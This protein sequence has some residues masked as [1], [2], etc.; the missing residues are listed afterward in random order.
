MVKRKGVSLKSEDFV[1]SVLRH[2]RD[3]MSFKVIAASQDM[4]EEYILDLDARD[5]IELTEGQTALLEASEPTELIDCIIENMNVTNEP[6]RILQCEHKV[7]F[8]HMF[9]KNHTPQ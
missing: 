7:F 8:S 2:K 4:G 5:L 6:H 9:V 3:P 1:V